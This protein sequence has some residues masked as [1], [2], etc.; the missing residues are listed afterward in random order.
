MRSTEIQGKL[1]LPE[2]RPAPHPGTKEIDVYEK[3]AANDLV[4]QLEEERKEG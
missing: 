3:E 4:Q 2:K 1:L